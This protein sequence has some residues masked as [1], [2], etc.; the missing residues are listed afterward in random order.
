MF[1]FQADKLLKALKGHFEQQESSD[2]VRNLHPK[3]QLKKKKSLVHLFTEEFTGIINPSLLD[4]Q[5][6][7]EGF[8]SIYLIIFMFGFG[9][10]MPHR[11][12]ALLYI[13]AEQQLVKC[14][15][16]YPPQG[17]TA[18][19]DDAQ[20][21]E[22]E[23]KEAAAEPKPKPKPVN[24]ALVTT[25]RGKKQQAKRKYSGDGADPNPKP[26]Q[27]PV[28]VSVRGCRASKMASFVKKALVILSVCLQDDTKSS[29]EE[30]AE[31]E[32]VVVASGDK[33]SSKRRKVSSA[34]DTETPAPEMKPESAGNNA[35]PEGTNQGEYDHVE[36]IYDHL[37]PPTSQG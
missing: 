4:I 25:R 30:A 21:Q 13:A 24:D 34:K 31:E 27:N 5:C 9:D 37:T 12:L 19:S 33:R 26:E 8:E 17:N 23:E 18:S 36:K 22:E 2:N 29:G 3:W 35:I 1:I 15:I 16:F 6:T 20:I 11:G 10:L 7:I 14:I 28:Q 32:E